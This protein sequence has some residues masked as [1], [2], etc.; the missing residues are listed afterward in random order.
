MPPPVV[1][2]TGCSKG[3]IGFNLAEEFA[4]KGCVVYASAR[5]PGSMEGFSRKE[6]RTVTLDVTNDGQVLEV[7][8]GVIDEEGRIDV[9]VNAAGTMAASASRFIL[10]LIFTS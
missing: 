3:G 10:L 8:R 1:L 6:I 9:V 4:E 7:V 2:I 5:R